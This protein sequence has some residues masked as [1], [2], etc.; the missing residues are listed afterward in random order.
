MQIVL[1]NLDLKNLSIHCCACCDDLQ[2]MHDFDEEEMDEKI[3]AAWEAFEYQTA[4]FFAA[5][6]KKMLNFK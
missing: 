2:A 5:L 3:Q 1:K 4:A 6:E